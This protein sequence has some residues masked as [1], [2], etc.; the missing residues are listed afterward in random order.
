[1]IFFPCCKVNLAAGKKFLISLRL[2]MIRR[3]G[4][5]ICILAL[6]MANSPKEWLHF[7][8][9]IEDCSVLALDH[10]EEEDEEGLCGHEAHFS[11]SPHECLLMHLSGKSPGVALKLSSPVSVQP[12]Q[13]FF[14]PVFT[15][16]VSQAYGTG[17]CRGPP[18]A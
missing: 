3:V 4:S 2:I 10:C 13:T 15:S 12:E 5:L 9:D 16:L 6:L 7:D 18:R 11:N 17:V 14:I 1:M 8:H